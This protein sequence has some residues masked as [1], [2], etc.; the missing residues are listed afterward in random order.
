LGAFFSNCTKFNQ[1]KLHDLQIVI[2]IYLH[3]TGIAVY[4]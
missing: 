2:L 4:N 3:T 1:L